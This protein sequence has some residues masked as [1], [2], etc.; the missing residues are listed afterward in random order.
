[1]ISLLDNCLCCEGGHQPAYKASDGRADV[2]F[3]DFERQLAKALGDSF[4]LRKAE[5]EE[6]FEDFLDDPNNNTIDRLAQ[7][8]EQ[9]D[10]IFSST[11]EGAE[12]KSKDSILGTIALGAA[13][14]GAASLVLNSHSYAALERG[15]NESLKYHTNKYFN[16]LVA[17]K[18]MEDVQKVLAGQS[19][20][21]INNFGFLREVLSK[22]LESTPYWRVVANASMSRGYH[23]GLV[24]AGQYAGKS[25]YVYNAVLDEKTSEV[26][27]TL[28]GKVFWIADAV[29]L[30]EKVASAD[31][32][33]VKRITPWLKA[34]EVVGKSNDDLRQLGVIVP[35]LHG[36]CRS[37]ITL[38]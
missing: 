8:L 2:R 31:P 26:C 16:E 15:V 35:P 25:G 36:N 34:S 7:R 13:G 27:Q 21:E 5:V 37:S 33:D 4:N 11:Y 23:Y 19:A 12:Q 6:L 1:M 17:P 14:L 24:K 10:A 20:L 29:N 18:I 28:D 32:Q 30:M 3:I 22:R 9:A 38:V